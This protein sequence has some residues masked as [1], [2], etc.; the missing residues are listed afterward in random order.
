EGTT[1][2]MHRFSS[3]PPFEK[4]PP[5]A[6]SESQL[7]TAKFQLAAFIG[8]YGTKNIYRGT[9]GQKGRPRCGTVTW[10]KPSGRKYP[11]ECRIIQHF[12][13]DSLT[14]SH[15]SPWLTRFRAGILGWHPP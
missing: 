4:P 7:C 5:Y 6:M 1:A 14:P 10:F 8:K 13:V 15:L 2:F 12:P 11:S 3:S 9:V